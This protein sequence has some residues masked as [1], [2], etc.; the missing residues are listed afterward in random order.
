LSRNMWN[1]KKLMPVEETVLL[2]EYMKTILIDAREWGWGPWIRL[3]PVNDSDARE[4]G[5]LIP[6]NRV[7][8]IEDIYPRLMPVVGTGL[9]WN[10]KGTYW[11]VCDASKLDFS[12]NGENVNWNWVEIEGINEGWSVWIHRLSCRELKGSWGL[13]AQ[14]DLQL[15]IERGSW[16]MV[17]RSLG[18]VVSL[19]DFTWEFP[20]L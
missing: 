10:F 12:N 5:W 7:G 20:R 6:V 3:I 17:K 4:W 8:K 14:Y 15:R 1:M 9:L 13:R 11:K 2:R 19:H 16:L 18:A